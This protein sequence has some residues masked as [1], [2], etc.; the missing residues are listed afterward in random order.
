MRESPRVEF[1]S[2][3]N[4]LNFNSSPFT[5]VFYICRTMVGL[6]KTRCPSDMSMRKPNSALKATKRHNLAKEKTLPQLSSTKGQPSSLDPQPCPDEIMPFTVSLPTELI[7]EILKYL[8][9]HG[10]EHAATALQVSRHYS[11]SLER[12]FDYR[13]YCHNLDQLNE[14][15]KKNERPLRL[16]HLEISLTPFSQTVLSLDS[17]LKEISEID[18]EVPRV[19]FKN[20]YNTV[21]KHPVSLKKSFAESVISMT[22]IETTFSQ[23]GLYETSS[24][25]ETSANRRRRRTY[26]PYSQEFRETYPDFTANLGHMSFTSCEEVWWEFPDQDKLDHLYHE[27]PISFPVLQYAYIVIPRLLPT[28][29]DDSIYLRFIRSNPFPATVKIA[30]IILQQ[31]KWPTREEIDLRDYTLERIEQGIKE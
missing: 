13:F 21:Y 30:L 23:I 19:E 24:Y 5:S 25:Y 29:Q 18:I 16:P 1:C 22:C 28:P 14:V 12:H 2:S 11:R 31:D 26:S 15:A 6:S 17:M 9:Y 7:L 27:H 8:C 4:R 10:P 3:I 20:L